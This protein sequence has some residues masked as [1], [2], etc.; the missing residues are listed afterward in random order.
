VAVAYKHP[1]TGEEIDYFPADT[2][3]LAQCEVVYKEFEGWQQE[4][5]KA[6]TWVRYSFAF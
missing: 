6:K 3:F 4:I 2:K 1:D 5:K